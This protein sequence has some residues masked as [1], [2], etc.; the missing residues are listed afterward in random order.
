MKTDCS[1]A[2]LLLVAV[3]AFYAMFG[4]TTLPKFDPVDSFAPATDPATHEQ[5]IAPSVSTLI[6]NIQCE[7][8]SAVRAGGP[9]FSGLTENI[10][11]AYANLTLEVT[12]NQGLAPTLA[13]IDPLSIAMTS[14]SLGINGQVTGQ[15]HRS[16]NQTFSL[17]IDRP[18]AGSAEEQKWNDQCPLD[19][20]NSS[21]NL[22]GNLGLKEIIKAGLRHVTAKDFL[23]R[24]P[25]LK[26]ADLG[27]AGLP[28]NP[29]LLPVFGSTIDFTVV[30]GLGGGPTWT[31]IHFTGPSGASGSLLNYMRTDKNTLVISFAVA[32]KREQGTEG[33]PVSVADFAAKRPVVQGGLSNIE[34]AGR[35][36]QD[37]VSLMILQRL[38]PAR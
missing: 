6:T 38:L 29:A 20:V 27:G 7:I 3:A 33:R 16:I 28:S 25:D 31:L 2:A 9:D 24:L 32:A 22:Q 13:F 37:N 17:V 19:A 15:E 21:R 1:R 23:F 14:K 4:C 5:G 26:D 34:L 12:D 36:A 11:V 35:V 18:A 10:Y 30:Y 8:I